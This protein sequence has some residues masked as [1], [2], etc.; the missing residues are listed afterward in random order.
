MKS[1]VAKFQ[2]P[3]LAFAAAKDTA[4]NCCLLATIQ[5]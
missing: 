5:G 4:K 1:F 3:L 2:V